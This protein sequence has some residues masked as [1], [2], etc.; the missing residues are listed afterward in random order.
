M[1]KEEYRAGA[2]ACQETLISLRPLLA[3]DSSQ[4]TAQYF[5]KRDAA[6]AAILAAAGPMPARAAGAMACFAEMVI[7]GEQ[8]GGFYGIGDI[9]TCEAA[10][11]EADRAQ[12]RQAFAE[13]CD[14]PENKNVTSLR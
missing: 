3:G 7:S 6:L 5:E 14:T 11:T 2:I 12:A 13:S 10:M 8:D 4:T 9:E 1:K